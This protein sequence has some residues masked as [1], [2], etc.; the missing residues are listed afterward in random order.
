MLADRNLGKLSP[1]RL[2]PVSCK[3]PQPSIRQSLGSP[4]EE[5]ETGLSEQER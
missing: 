3:D 1:E 2:H 4:E 5:W